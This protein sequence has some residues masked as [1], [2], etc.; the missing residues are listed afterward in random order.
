MENDS[1]FYLTPVLA[2]EAMLSACEEAL[3]SIDCEQYIFEPDEIGERFATLF[4]KKVAEGVRV[5]LLVDGIGSYRF[6][7]SPLHTRLTE[8]GV[9]VVV[10]NPPRL[11]RKPQFSS[12]FLRDHRKILVVDS[13]VGFTGGV[14]ISSPMK[15]WRDTQVRFE[16][17]LAREVQESF[18]TMWGIGLHGGRLH[19]PKKSSGENSFRILNNSPRLRH[20]H[21]YH[22]LLRGIKAATKY[23][24]LETGYFVPSFRLTHALRKAAKRGVDVRIMLS[25]VSDVLIT[26]IAARSYFGG[27]LKAGVKIYRYRNNVF[28]AKT[29]VVDDMWALAGSANLDNL[30]LLLNYESALYGTES[31]F[32]REVKEQFIHDMTHADQVILSEWARRPFIERLQELLVWPLRGIL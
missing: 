26:D 4:I 16:G 30:S 23:V 10:F 17:D 21:I 13:R 15:S 32:V 25:S 1:R 20:R 11:F 18:E 6:I 31:S 24:Y 22:T 5:R 8:E 29:A 27:L 28:H 7:D 12:H 9:E 19:F 2:W 14:G 3:T